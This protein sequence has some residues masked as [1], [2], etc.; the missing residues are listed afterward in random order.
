MGE[1]LKIGEAAKLLSVSKETLR[2]WDRSGKLEAD[3]DPMNNYRIYDLNQILEVKAKSG[4]D[5]NIAPNT[6]SPN[7]A[8]NQPSLFD[9]DERRE[10]PNQRELRNLVRKMSAAFRDSL[11][12]SLMERF[13]EITKLL[14]ARLYDQQANRENEQFYRESQESDEGTRKRVAALYRAACEQL[15]EEHRSWSQELSD[16]ARAVADIVSLLQNVDLYSVPA[17]VKGVV[18]EELIRDTFEK[19]ENQQYFTPRG[20]VKAVVHFM[21]PQPNEVICDPACGTG[22]FL[23]EAAEQVNV[24]TDAV[25][26]QA[27]SGKLIGLEIDH[28]MAWVAQMNLAMHGDGRGRVH[29]LGRG[30]SLA[31]SDAVTARVDPNSVDV[32]LTNPPFGSEVTDQQILNNYT[33]G[34]G[35]SSRRRGTL[36]IE[37][38]LDFLRPG[39][40]MGIVIEDSVL[41]GASNEDIRAYILDNAVVKAVVSLPEETFMPYATAKTSLLFLQ[42]KKKKE[43]GETKQPQIFMAD[44]EKVGRKPNGDPDYK[45]EK[46]ADGKPVLDTELP[47]VVKAWRNYSREG[48]DA[49]SHLSPKIFL[50]P[51]RR[52]AYDGNS[53]KET[54]LDVQYHHPSRNTAEVT[55]G[56]SEYPIHKLAELVVFR[57]DNVVPNDEDP[58]GTWRYVGLGDIDARIGRYQVRTVLGKEV[59]S[60]VRRFEG[61]DILFSKMR[62]GLR[63]CVLIDEDEETG[64][65][66]S[67]CYVMRSPSTAIH[68]SE[69]RDRAMKRQ[70]LIEHEVLP[71]YLAFVLRSD[72]VFGQLVYQVTGLGR[73][74]VNKSTIMN[75]Q[76]PLP[77][78]EIQQEI[79][80]AHGVA[81]QR[82][83]ECIKKSQ[84]IR[85]E[86]EEAL[87]SARRFAVNKLCPTG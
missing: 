47:G 65:V 63:K 7:A 36:F 48:E 45:L 2:N 1:R 26:Q 57:T 82:Y 22:G 76:I 43:K 6:A 55:L 56:R 11:G 10:V 41:N 68:D 24:D 80:T 73:P 16:D 58:E 34:Q 77:P 71:E 4:E 14:Y 21:N 18:F 31:Y 70:A 29:K 84:L 79:V 81:W 75:L 53:R 40:R 50:C 25:E 87:D 62:P 8:N 51:A 46:S 42:K 12:G 3:R 30:G 19:S 35:R 20:V 74:R 59:R 66:S 78:K 49:I 54:R 69:L 27:G 52:F 44:V 33:L 13:E 83:V 85:E 23:I 5:L 61:G 32:I 39:G 72:I 15:P 17:D 64:Y 9:T 28:R 86:G 38:C 60:T 67:E 37:R